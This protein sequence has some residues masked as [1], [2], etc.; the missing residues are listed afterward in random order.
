MN[1]HFIVPIENGVNTASY[2]QRCANPSHS[3]SILLTR[4]SFSSSG[5]ISNAENSAR[6]I[7]LPIW[8]P[9]SRPLSVRVTIRL[10][11]S[12]GSML[13]VTQPRFS[14]LSTT[15]VTVCLDKCS[16]LLSSFCVIGSQFLY[17]SVRIYMTLVVTPQSDAIFSYATSIPRQLL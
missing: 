4:L 8:R 11:R 3:F 9:V 7:V 1:R 2:A 6:R 10:R 14:R 5:S 12:L 16:S 17:S 13:R 15:L